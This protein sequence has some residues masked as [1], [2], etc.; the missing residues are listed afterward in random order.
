MKATTHEPQ[1]DIEELVE[2]LAG[3]VVDEPQAVRVRRKGS[4]LF[5]Q[6]AA[7]EEG[8][9]I[10]RQGRVIQAIRAV[11]RAATPPRTRLNIDLAGQSRNEGRNERGRNQGHAQQGARGGE[12]R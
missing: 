2:F 9:L 1:M 3:Q 7:G 4:N 10:G 8:R 12:G 6:V 5:V 11:A